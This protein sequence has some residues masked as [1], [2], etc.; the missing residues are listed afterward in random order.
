MP[1]LGYTWIRVQSEN[2]VSEP[3]AYK[4]LISVDRDGLFYLTMPEE[5]FQ[6][7]RNL[8]RSEKY[9][10][11][12]IGKARVNWV[13]CSKIK[14]EAERFLH[15]VIS[16]HLAC[17]VVRELVIV[18]KSSAD[19]RYWK[20]AS[21]RIVPNGAYDPNYVK[22]EGHWGGARGSTYVSRWDTPD[23]YTLGLI[24]GVFTKVTLKRA[25]GDQVSWE[26]AGQNYHTEP[27][28]YLDKLNSFV[29]GI[30]TANVGSMNQIPYTEEAARFFYDAMI[31]LCSLSDRITS[32]FGDTANVTKAIES[33]ASFLLA[34]PTSKIKT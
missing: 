3:F 22:Q 32:F 13:V 16:E 1:S 10:A 27:D 26:R 15:V 9:R 34:P 8:R 17:Q 7:A 12:K 21:G 29:H 14:D 28:L 2:S 30:D 6:T 18:Y 5:M 25:S 11:I 24:A 23:T 19:L 4:S 20:M 31:A 33:R